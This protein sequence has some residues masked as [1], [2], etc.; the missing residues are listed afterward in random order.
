MGSSC[1]DD[2]EETA[3]GN[4]AGGGGDFGIVLPL[5]CADVVEDDDIIEQHVRQRGLRGFVGLTHV[6]KRRLSA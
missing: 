6:L 3:E 4:G 2:E 1:I 5:F